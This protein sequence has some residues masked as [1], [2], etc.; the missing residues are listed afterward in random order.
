MIRRWLAGC[1]GGIW[2]CVIQPVWAEAPRLFLSPEQRDSIERG[3]Q[4]VDTTP[5]AASTETT[6]S[7]VP[8]ARSKAEPVR[9]SAIIITP[10]GRKWARRNDSYQ[11]MDSN[12]HS[13]RPMQVELAPNVHLR[14]GEAYDPESGQVLPLHRLAEEA[15]QMEGT[16][17]TDEVDLTRQIQTQLPGASDLLLPKGVR[18]TEETD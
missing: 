16:A 17:T 8:S 14:V 12:G 5:E 1:I 4:T 9:I 10:D 3:R 15:A 7:D 6:D 2:L 11:L 13:K 18:K